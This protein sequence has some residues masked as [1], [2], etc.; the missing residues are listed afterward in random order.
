MLRKLMMVAA[1]AA[2]PLG[3]VALTAGTASAKAPPPPSPPLNCSA[4]GTVTF[5]PPGISTNGSVSPNKTSTTTT[6]GLTLSGAGCG[7]GG[8][9]PANAIVAKSTVKCSK[10]VPDQNSTGGSQPGCLPGDRVYDQASAFASTGTATLQKALKKLTFTVNGITFSA[11]T[12]SATTSGA[13]QCSGEIGFVV[14]GTVKAKPFTYSTFTLI[15]CLGADTGPNTTNSF[16]ADI[17]AS[18]G[19]NTAITIATATIDGGA[20]ESSLSIS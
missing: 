11:K 18:L 20:G 8:S 1:A 2:I 3:G 12:T 10:K 6:S 16:L 5:A 19:G 9:E 15:A 17:A 4:S 13:G 14:S 7:T